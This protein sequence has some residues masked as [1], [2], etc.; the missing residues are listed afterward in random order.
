MQPQTNFHNVC[1][2]ILAGQPLNCPDAPAATAS[3]DSIQTLVESG[4]TLVRLVRVLPHQS[5]KLG[6]YPPTQLIVVLDAAAIT[7]GS[8]MEREKEKALKPGEFVWL[9]HAV[10]SD[11]PPERGE[12]RNPGDRA[13]RF[14][15]IVFP[16]PQ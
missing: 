7:S 3:G 14:I 2:E 8:I 6:D 12:Y 5:M 15:E 4:Q 11:R 1:A 16:D 13:A 9:D 10:W